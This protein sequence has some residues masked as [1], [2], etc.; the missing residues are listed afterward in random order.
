LW[1]R[2]NLIRC[3]PKWFPT[4]LPCYITI[5][6]LIDDAKK[7][8]VMDTSSFASINLSLR[9]YTCLIVY[10]FA[11][12]FTFALRALR[13][14]YH[15]GAAYIAHWRLLE[16]STY[17]PKWKMFDRKRTIIIKDI[18][19]SPHTVSKWSYSLPVLWDYGEYFVY[20]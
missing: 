19:M 17:L 20:I 13:H 9:T 15:L 8:N 4:A 12:L 10:N 1:C 18:K 7:C 2:R 6:L 14:L 5:T 16:K 3:Q 11:T